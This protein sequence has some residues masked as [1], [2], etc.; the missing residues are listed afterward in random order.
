MIIHEGLYKDKTSKISY[1][2]VKPISWNKS[3]I[4]LLLGENGVGKTR[5]IEGVLLK[6]LKQD[7]KRILYFGQDLE[8]QI[9]TFELINLV[10]HFIDTLKKQGNF[11]RAILFNHDSHKNIDLDF[12]SDSVLNPTKSSIKEFIL[13]ESKRYKIDV[14]ILDEVDKYFSG[15][16]EFQD[17]LNSVQA[18]KIFII[19][20]ILDNREYHKMNLYTSNGEVIIE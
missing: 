15:K 14:L 13:K 8:N 9:L 1:R 4:T 11:F 18:S 6:K 2:V 10:K 19:S 7:K 17:Y 12:D 5:F 16:E 20:H 3:K